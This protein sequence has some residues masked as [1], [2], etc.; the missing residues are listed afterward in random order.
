[1]KKGL[2]WLEDCEHNSGRVIIVSDDGKKAVL[3]AA[4]YAISGIQPPL[5]ELPQRQS[6]ATK[7]R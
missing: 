5:Y 4:H 2:V 3:P 6:G 1:M 7:G